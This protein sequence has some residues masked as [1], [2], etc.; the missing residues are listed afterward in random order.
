M[1]STFQPGMV[2][3]NIAK[4]VLPHA[5]GNAPATYLISP[6]SLV[7]LRINICSASQPSSLAIV[8][9]IRSAKH[10]FPS[11]ALPP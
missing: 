2:G 4:L 10:F 5:L 3:V 6:V 11:K 9:A 8:D 7:S 1:V